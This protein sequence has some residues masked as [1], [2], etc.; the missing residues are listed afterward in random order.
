MGLK[1]RRQ[2]RERRL[3]AEKEDMGVEGGGSAVYES[4]RDRVAL[5]TARQQIFNTNFTRML[6]T[7][8]WATLG[9]ALYTGCKHLEEEPL[10]F[11]NM[12]LSASCAWFTQVWLRKRTGNSRTRSVFPTIPTV[13][14]VADILFFAALLR[15]HTALHG[16]HW[17][18]GGTFCLLSQIMVSVMDASTSALHDTSKEL[19]EKVDG[20]AD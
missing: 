18:I 8:S 20:R 12:A 9:I 4:A 11:I 15:W 10:V 17:P 1:R 7:L 6:V 16:R 5:L 19:A 2:A 13:L 14:A 3:A